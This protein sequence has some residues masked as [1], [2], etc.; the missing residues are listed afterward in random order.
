MIGFAD[1]IGFGSGLDPF[2]FLV[3]KSP[4]V[5][6][7]RSGPGCGFNAGTKTGTLPFRNRGSVPLFSLAQKSNCA[8]SLKY[9]ADTMANGSRNVERGN[10][11][12]A[13]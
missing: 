4:H 8:P 13:V 3:W 6:R 1:A 2:Q 11:E 10:V 9:R 7:D 12:G 5:L